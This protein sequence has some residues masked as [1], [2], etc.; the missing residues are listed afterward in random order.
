[1]T[2][3]FI[4]SCELLWLLDPIRFGD[5]YWIDMMNMIMY[6][7]LTI[8]LVWLVSA[9]IGIAYLWKNRGKKY[10]YLQII[11]VLL[12]LAIIISSACVIYL[13]V[14]DPHRL[15]G[16]GIFFAMTW[17]LV[18]CDLI[19]FE[20]LRKNRVPWKVLLNFGVVIGILTLIVCPTAYSV[21][22]PG[23]TMNMNQYA[24][25][26]GGESAS[27]IMGVLIFE[28]PAVPMD[29]LY[30]QLFPHYELEKRIKSDLSIGEQLQEVA[31]SK[32]EAN[33]TASAVAFQKVG[34]GKGATSHGALIIGIVKGSPASD[35][36]H[37]GDVII[38]LDEGVIT[39]TEQLIQQMKDIQ[40]GAEVDLVLLRNGKKISAKIKTKADSKTNKAVMGISIMD[41]IVLDLPR[42]VDFQPYLVHE[43]GPSHGAM[44]TLALIDQLTP[45]GITKGN[46]V[47][48]TGTIRYD[49]S[50][51]PIGGIEQKAYSVS[52]TGADVF[53]VPAMQMEE[54]RKG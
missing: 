36:L 9:M 48:G 42:K 33:Q 21:T 30:T 29:W 10:T 34:I 8:P 47:A 45:E 28:R 1:M 19:I 16:I 25:V 50:I 15:I 13:I 52:R 46:K 27:E 41:D 17:L 35:I 49:G 18:W 14:L 40:P 24:R 43:G 6:V 12:R 20:W 39:S 31:A 5:K 3:L 11:I 22:Y 32:Y 51:G 4:L 2:L 7:C 23:L 26:Q 54:A 38:Q 53:F 44:L 37:A